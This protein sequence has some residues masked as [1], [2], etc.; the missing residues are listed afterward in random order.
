MKFARGFTLVAA[1]CAALMAAGAADAAKSSKKTAKSMNAAS[2]A[3]SVAGSNSSA[4]AGMGM[5]GG[6]RMGPGGPGAGFLLDKF[7]EI[8]TSKNGEL[9]KAEIE[10]WVEARRAEMKADFEAKFKAADTD[11]DGALTKEEA[12]AAF[13]RMADHFDIIDADKDGKITV[14]ELEALRDPLK[15]REALE[16][17]FKATDTSGDGKL[18][19]AEVTSGL[20]GLVAKFS[21]IDKDGDG[22]LTPE[23]LRPRHGRGPG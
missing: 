8:D 20:P 10:A 19:L 16:A 13:P 4:M 5:G 18:D 22:Y 2:A 15:M 21:L 12:A 1:V 17:K 14:A 9:S 23:E 3:P 11:A 7:D 6:P